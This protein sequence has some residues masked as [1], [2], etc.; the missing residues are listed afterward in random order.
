MS[1]TSYE[2]SHGKDLHLIVVRRDLS[3]YRHVH[4]VLGNAGTKIIA[5][6]IY[7][8]GTCQQ[9]GGTVVSPVD[10]GAEPAPDPM[11]SLYGPRQQDYPPGHCPTR[12]GTNI[13]YSL[14][15]TLMVVIAMTTIAVVPA[16][17]SASA[18]MP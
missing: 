3:D 16:G 4:P 12:Q 17:R 7:I 15:P 14:A 18:R 8:V 2:K 6:M 11:A 10:E 9:S 1:V 13:V 5:P